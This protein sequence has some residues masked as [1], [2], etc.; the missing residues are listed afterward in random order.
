GMHVARQVHILAAGHGHHACERAV[1]Q[2][3]AKRYHAADEPCR[4]HGPRRAEIG[5]REPGRRED[6]GADHVADYEG[7]QCR[8]PEDRAARS[9][10]AG[11][12]GAS[13]GRSS[14]A[15]RRYRPPDAATKRKASPLLHHR[16]CVGGGPSSNTWPWCP[17][18]RAQWYSVRGHNSTKSRF[19][20]KTSGIVVKKL[21]QPVPLSNF[22][23][24]VNNGSAQPAQMNSPGRFSS[25]NGLENAGSVSSSRSTSNRSSPSRL[26]HCSSESET[27]SRTLGTSKPAG[28]SCCHPDRMR[29]TSAAVRSAAGAARAASTSGAALKACSNLLLS[30]VVATAP[31]PLR[32][33]R[34]RA[35]RR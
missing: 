31:A 3:A 10:R 26:R 35:L 11:R 6:A 12:G 27:R 9:H 20:S 14:I 5:E 2:R 33:R 18:Q 17:P 16:S 22:I 34:S 7:R 19:V 30:M 15:I 4:E 32:S 13:A 25:F 29:S 21:G 23:S 8:S 1:A 28:T 24:D